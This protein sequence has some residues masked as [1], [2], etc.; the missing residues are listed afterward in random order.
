VAELQKH[1]SDKI[2]FTG[3]VYGEELQELYS[4]AYCYVHPSTIE[5]LPVTLLEGVAYGNCVIAS[6]IPANTEV[7]EDNGVIFESMNVDDLCEALKM[8][9]A[10]PAL[11][12]ELGERAMA[13]GVAE[14]NYDKVTAKTEALYRRVLSGEM[15]MLNSTA[16]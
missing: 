2:I 7:V 9:I 11:A 15:P 1:A 13:H 12:R 8:V 16:T 4:N 5:G 10:N 3:Y 14:Y 6:D